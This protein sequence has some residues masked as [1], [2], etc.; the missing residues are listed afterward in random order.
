M[1]D[2]FISYAREDLWH[3]QRLYMDLR[4]ADM[5]C[6]IDVKCLLPGMNWDNTIQGIIRNC[7][8]FIFFISEHSNLNERYLL[9]EVELALEIQETL[10]AD[11]VYIIPIRL[12]NIIPSKSE[13]KKYNYIDFFSAYDKGLGRVL[14]VLENVA[15]DPLVIRGKNVHVGKRAAINF[16]PF[17][18]FAGFIRDV[19]KN[20]PISSAFINTENG[21]YFTFY[22][23]HQQVIIPENLREK[24][25]KEMTLVL[26]YSYDSFM[27]YQDYLTVELLFNGV[28]ENLTIPY[29]SI[30]QVVSTMGFKIDRVDK[31][32][33]A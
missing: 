5:D 24:Y 15:K 2:I 28:Q 22:T 13:L 26:Q 1:S 16:E 4:I 7:K 30:F 8:Y 18:N 27:L 23:T 17:Q 11:K 29:D 19:L 9:R 10:P 3:A 12:D 31:N 32:T 20:Y 33:P 25:P 21:L 14:T 6:W